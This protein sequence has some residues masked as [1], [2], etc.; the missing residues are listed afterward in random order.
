MKHLS[1]ETQTQRANVGVGKVFQFSFFCRAPL[2]IV[3]EKI[4]NQ[5]I[6]DQGETHT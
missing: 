1:L 4:E 6:Q 5:N 2:L 3:D